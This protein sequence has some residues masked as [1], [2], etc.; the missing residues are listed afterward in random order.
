MDF[1]IAL[2]N[3][4]CDNLQWLFDIIS[5][6]D[7]IE[8]CAADPNCNLYQWRPLDSVFFH[9]DNPPGCSIGSFGVMHYCQPAS[10]S[11][12]YLISRGRAHNSYIDCNVLKELNWPSDDWPNDNCCLNH[13]ID[14]S[15][16][17]ESDR[18]VSLHL[19]NSQLAGQLESIS[20]LT[21]LQTLHLSHNSING[22]ICALRSLSKLKIAWLDYNQLTGSISCGLPNS[23]TE[24]S[25][26]YNQL[27]GQLES[28]STL[29]E[30]TVLQLQQ[31]GQVRISG[32]ICALKSLSKLTNL[33][34]G[35]NELTGNVVCFLHQTFP[36]LGD[37][38]LPLNQLS[39]NID[40][41]INAPMLFTLDF[42]CNNFTGS[43]SIL[44]SLSNL[45]DVDLSGNRFTGSISFSKDL[46]DLQ[47]LAISNNSLT[48]ALP[49]LRRL[50]MLT[51]IN[52]SLNNFTGSVAELGCVSSLTWADLNFNRFDSGLNELLSIAF[53]NAQPNFTWLFL[54]NNS[55]QE[56]LQLPN[57]LEKNNRFLFVLAE[58]NDFNCPY[59]Q[60]V[61]GLVISKN[62][63]CNF[64]AL[65][66][67]SVPVGMLCLA[68][69]GFWVYRRF[70]FPPTAYAKLLMKFGFWISNQYTFIMSII[71]FF[72][73]LE[74]L[75]T[76]PPNVCPYLNEP[77]VFWSFIDPSTLAGGFK[78]LQAYIEWAL[79]YGDVSKD[80]L[81]DQFER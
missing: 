37:L 27:S 15:I 35:G 18:I 10:S 20:A 52:V 38:Q 40:A 47:S 25:L 69:I 33:W 32:S 70:V 54:Q 3:R 34:L 6:E 58:N 39:G 74:S 31:S 57:D 7:C 9:G 43:I 56:R 16:I 5:L 63:L 76:P 2:D 53:S 19:E 23:L 78:N 29:T 13:L 24:L 4:Q 73:A 79:S 17:C 22:S 68:L 21:E 62:L 55:F 77:V 45:V 65:L 48:G 75:G 11:N 59:P 12:T 80:G 1:S 41:L 44:N 64:Q 49:N 26:S 28:I 61:S 50:P 51:M 46:P 71:Y 66:Y 72:D 14:S 30:L 8:F 60:E 81:R 42:C 36:N 67:A